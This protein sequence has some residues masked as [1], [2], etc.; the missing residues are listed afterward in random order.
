MPAVLAPQ[1]EY[2]H[3]AVTV[4][5]I[6]KLTM[7]GNTTKLTKKTRELRCSH[8]SPRDEWIQDLEKERIMKTMACWQTK[9]HK[10]IWFYSS[11]HYFLYCLRNWN[12]SQTIADEGGLN[13]R[14]VTTRWQGIQYAEAGNHSISN[15]C[16][17]WVGTILSNQ[18]QI[19]SLNKC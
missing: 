19:Q 15:S 10:S 4:A 14:L 3:V 7:G 5:K 8:E 13:P 6:K 18:T 17:H 1:A 12:L 16:R 2:S 11:I 9:C